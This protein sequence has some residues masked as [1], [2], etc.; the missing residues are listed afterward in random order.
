MAGLENPLEDACPIENG[1]FSNVMFSG[2]YTTV[3][4]KS[5]DDTC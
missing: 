2:V 5:G 4:F 1:V 3:V